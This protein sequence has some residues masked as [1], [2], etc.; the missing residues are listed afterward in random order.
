MLKRKGPQRY[1]TT[2]P[3]PATFV[4]LRR[5]VGRS[6]RPRGVGAHPFEPRKDGVIPRKT[7]L[8]LREDVVR[9]ALGNAHWVPFR[10]RSPRPSLVSGAQVWKRYADRPSAADHLNPCA[11][12]PRVPSGKCSEPS[13]TTI[14]LSR[15]PQFW[16]FAKK[17][18]CCQI[19]Q[20]KTMEDKER[21]HRPDR[22]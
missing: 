14:S 8:V 2:V 16:P 17:S 4:Q 7:A 22:R 21:S 3:I 11:S 13:T 1:G 15:W 5:W 18:I 19:H 20:E 9:R 12:V 6:L 10:R